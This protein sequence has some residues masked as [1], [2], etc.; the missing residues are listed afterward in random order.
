MRRAATRRVVRSELRT[1]LSHSVRRLG[2]RLGRTVPIWI[3]RRILP[4]PVLCLCY[5]IVSDARIAHVQHYDYLGNAEFEHDLGD[6]ESRF[7][8]VSY[9]QTVELRS[10]RERGGGPSVC[11]SFDDGFA[12]CFSV[13]RPILLRHRATC[14][15]FVITD[16]IDN[17]TVF[18]ET[19]ASLC[20]ESILRLP[21]D[22]VES[23]IRDLNLEARLSTTDSAY[24]GVPTQMA[25]K[26]RRFE[27]RLRPLLI[28]LLT[29]RPAE[30]VL[31]DSLCR[32]LDVDAAGYVDKVKPYL[33]TEQIQQLRSDGF[34]IGAHGCSHRRLQE[35]SLAE[36]ETEIV[37][38]C[39]VIHRLTGQESVPFAF[40][41]SGRGLDRVWLAK[42]RERHPFIGLFF[43]TQGLRHDA[44]FVVQRV[45]GERFE[46]TGS[47]DRLLRR[48][49]TRRL[50]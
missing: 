30:A 42:L 15:F 50:S 24:G 21:V 7:G 3:W 40:P 18:L 34:A 47:I 20:V 4:E 35:L 9:E 11:L 13:A 10:K 5:H 29:I 6:L 22:A 33:S 41:Y 26:W 12:E 19:K 37:E 8:Y 28:W 46:E 32:R 27:P 31:L 36:A 25:E 45:F 49:W 23:I 16:L 17:R 44:E 43:D 1:A 39:R 14:I 2:G 38:S 48:A